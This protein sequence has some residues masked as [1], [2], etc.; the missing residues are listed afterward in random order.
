MS[1]P[2]RAARQALL[3]AV[4]AV[5]LSGR[6]VAASAGPSSNAGQEEV[7]FVA[8]LH[9]KWVD[10][11]HHDQLLAPHSVVWSDSQIRLAASRSD[12]FIRIR[13][14]GRPTATDFSCATPL[15]CPGPLDLRGEL[16][17]IDS[18]VIARFAQVID[19]LKE[20]L[21][22]PPPGGENLI[23]RGD[24]AAFGPPDV[25][26]VANE[27]AP[28]AGWIKDLPAGHYQAT[29]ARFA[30]E[31]APRVIRLDW[32]ASRQVKLSLE[33]GLYQL[34]LEHPADPAVRA[35][36]PM[37]SLVLAVR[38]EGYERALSMLEE[39]RRYAATL[40]DASSEE[41]RILLRY[42]MLDLASGG[43]S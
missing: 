21:V 31:A 10:Q 17:R 13:F 34:T 22:A 36:S 1:A 12:Y 14:Y 41:V 33:P 2:G 3:L 27:P 15:V 39:G 30:S 32:P 9:G 19:A 5:A 26:V 28:L 25:V 6:T 40:Q 37:V 7:G 4:A 43:S 42:L 18:G 38:R 11:T 23:A 20:M 35:T 24:N 16:R 29:L 8:D